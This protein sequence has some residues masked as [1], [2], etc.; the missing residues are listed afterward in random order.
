MIGLM[1][2]TC[3]ICLFGGG[4]LGYVLRS[5][6]K[7]SLQE[8][9]HQLSRL[10]SRETSELIEVLERAWGLSSTPSRLPPAEAER[11]QTE[12]T[13]NGAAD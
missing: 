2:I 13:Q 8:F 9:E 7:M 1:I 11:T 6:A 5:R 4:L 12:R 3:T 10:D